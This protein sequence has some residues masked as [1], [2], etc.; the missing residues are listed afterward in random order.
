M[1][2]TGYNQNLQLE[3]TPA[4]NIIMNIIMNIRHFTEII[5]D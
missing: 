3:R 2:Q 4:L 5:S 1:E